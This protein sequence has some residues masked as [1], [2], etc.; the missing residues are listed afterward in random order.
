[1]AKL[2]A[3]E[4]TILDMF[5]YMRPSGTP[6]EQVFIDRF[7]TPLGFTRDPFRNLVLTVGDRPN[8]L[9]SSHMDTVHRE[10]GIQTL[11]YDGEFLG[12]GK[13][14][15]SSTC[16]GADDT[17][18]IWI[19]T[20]MVKAGVPGV[21]VIH[22]GEE[23]GCKGSRALAR[24][25]PEFFEGIDAAIAFDRMGYNSVIT[26]QM[27]ARTASDA[28]AASFADALDDALGIDAGFKADDGG[29]YTDTNEYADIVS[30]CTNISVGY[31]SQ[32]SR[33]ETQHVPFLIAM[34]NAMVRMDLSAL[35]FARDP[36]VVDYAGSYGFYRGYKSL[37]DDDPWDD[38]NNY[39]IPDRR[40]DDSIEE[41]IKAYPEIVAAIL[42]SYGLTRT[43]LLDEIAEVYGEEALIAN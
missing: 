24:G 6:M 5:Q 2:T 16:L 40:S 38:P 36:S 32:H 29:A 12:I 20:E 19:M 39:V 9:W 43:M 27:G 14:A 13:K 22:H 34:R 23:I 37:F 31:H 33:N 26:H 17:A 10:E 35:V 3:D 41:V 25:N 4:K 7:L 8:I 11:H 42:H 30:E 18:G 15:K 21:Y 1:M 28:F